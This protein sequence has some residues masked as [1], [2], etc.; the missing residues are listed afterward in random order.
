MAEVAIVARPI[1]TFEE[2]IEEVD[3]VEIV[4]FKAD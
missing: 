3:F 1:K 4:V 2:V